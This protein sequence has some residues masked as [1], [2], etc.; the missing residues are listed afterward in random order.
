MDMV[1]A[2]AGIS[3]GGLTYTY[4]SKDALIEDMLRREL[5]R[6]VDQREDKARS[7][8]PHERVVAHVEVSGQQKHLYQTR[9]AHLM[10]ALANE[11]RHLRVVQDF[12]REVF[13]LINDTT[14][15][16]KR[17]RQAVLAIEGL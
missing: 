13:D 3:K 15:E 10:A 6:F 11:P 9:A 8:N 12:Y 14:P 4:P 1:A 7:S 16:G 17:I 2:R 5:S